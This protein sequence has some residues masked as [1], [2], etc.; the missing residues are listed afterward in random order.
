MPASRGVLVFGDQPRHSF[1]LYGLHKS[2][3]G[4]ISCLFIQFTVYK[5]KKP[6][7]LLSGS[8]CVCWWVKHV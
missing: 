3:K 1:I 8:V 6:D 4:Y 2:T 5:H 7:I